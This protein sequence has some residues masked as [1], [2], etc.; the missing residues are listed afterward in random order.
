MPPETAGHRRVAREWGSLLNVAS[1]D[2][3][4]P[5][6]DQ[7][8]GDLGSRCRQGA[9]KRALGDAHQPGTLLLLQPC[10]VF[11][12]HGFQLVEAKQDLIK[13]AHRNTGRL[14]VD[15]F[16]HK[17]YTPIFGWSRQSYPPLCRLRTESMPI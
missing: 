1:L 8:L 2:A 3:N 11:E 7:G 6:H 16:G 9:L 13:L 10:Q 12:A 15:D 14:E 5:A 17:T 4:R